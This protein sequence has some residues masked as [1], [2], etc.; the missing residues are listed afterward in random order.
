VERSL[1]YSHVILVVEHR[2]RLWLRLEAEGE[3][4]ATSAVMVGEE[5][6]Q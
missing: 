6:I 2:L 3:G 5:G 1:K 4:T